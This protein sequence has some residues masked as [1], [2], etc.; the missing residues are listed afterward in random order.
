MRHGSHP[1]RESTGTVRDDSPESLPVAVVRPRRYDIP[2]HH[3]LLSEGIIHGAGHLR[4][5][6]A[7]ICPEGLGSLDVK[8]F[9]TVGLGKGDSLLACF[10][11]PLPFGP[12]I[13]QADQFLPV[14]RSLVRIVSPASEREFP[15]VQR[16][17][18]KK[19][20]TRLQGLAYH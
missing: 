8:E 20:H 1:E 2:E 17:G 3:D 4:K 18:G 6:Y 5:G 9:E 10:P 7:L 11:C 16:R 15:V 13:G 12:V 19:Q 14:A